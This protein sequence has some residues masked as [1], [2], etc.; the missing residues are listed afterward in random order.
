MTDRLV[1]CRFLERHSVGSSRRVT[2]VLVPT[3]PPGTA[4]AG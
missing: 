1:V 2:A 4:C 3:S